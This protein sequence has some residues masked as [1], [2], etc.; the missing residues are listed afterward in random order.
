M[1]QQ[2]QPKLLAVQVPLHILGGCTQF[3]AVSSEQEHREWRQWKLRFTSWIALQSPPMYEMLDR[4]E[5]HPDSEVA[6]VDLDPEQTA[7]SLQLHSLLLAYTQGNAFRIVEE[8]RDCCGG[9]AYRR[10][11]CENEPRTTSRAAAIMECIMSYQPSS[12]D[13][14]IRQ[15]VA[16]IEVLFDTY[17]STTGSEVDNIMKVAILMRLLKPELKRHVQLQIS[18][19]TT[20]AKVR[21]LITDYDRATASWAVETVSWWYSSW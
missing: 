9:E 17:R 2:Q 19:T 11:L 6:M 18:D 14:S 10:L 20:Y 3:G 21:D 12:K 4:V 5:A 8:V 16:E 15:R 13:L 1:Q 7:I